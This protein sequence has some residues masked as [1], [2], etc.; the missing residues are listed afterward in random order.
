MGLDGISNT[1]STENYQRS[2]P[3]LKQPNGK[4]QKSLM[5]IGTL[6]KE[7]PSDSSLPRGTGWMLDNKSD[8][9][10]SYNAIS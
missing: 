9:K 10:T 1:D 4:L 5:A 6:G 3:K 7:R 2:L 8:K